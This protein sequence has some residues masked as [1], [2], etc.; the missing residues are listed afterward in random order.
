M[1]APQV[2]AAHEDLKQIATLFQQEGS[3]IQGTL[4]QLRKN[5]DQLQGG[6]WKGKG[7]TAFF[8]EMNS[9]ILPSMR[10]LERALEQAGRVTSQISARMRQCEADAADQ[11]QD[12]T[13][14]NGNPADS[15]PGNGG[16]PGGEGGGGTAPRP[17]GTPYATGSGQ[18]GWSG[19]Y[20]PSEPGPFGWQA[21]GVASGQYAGGQVEA[22]VE[23]VGNITA[24][25][26]VLG[27]E[28]GWG[29]NRDVQGAYAEGSVLQGKAEF[30]LGG[31]EDGFYR[32]NLQVD[33]LSGSAYAGHRGSNY[34]IGGEVN[35]VKVTGGSVI[36]TKDV[37]VTTGGELA[38]P[39]ANAYA[40]VKDGSIGAEAGYSLVGAKVEGGF[41][42]FGW[43]IGVVGEADLGAGIG[44]SV[45]K[46]TSVKFGPFAIGITFGSAK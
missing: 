44:A 4:A 3:N 19:D 21:G 8:Q 24:G 40:G 43:N 30:Q 26:R 36:G 5:L 11:L 10:N 41:N 23:G 7:A 9:S 13:D 39:S 33:V 12:R 14:W 31:G 38:G 37:G 35:T 17:F 42:V 1:P 22:G 34:G 2:R 27:G 25:G 45:G 32:Q 29:W 46:K 20:K 18:S 28:A 6:G 16:G 15:S